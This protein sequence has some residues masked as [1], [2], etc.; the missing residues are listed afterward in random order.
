MG[1]AVPAP[2]PGPCMEPFED[3]VQH[4][5]FVVQD[6]AVGEGGQ[7]VDEF[8]KPGGGVRAVAGLQPRR[9]TGGGQ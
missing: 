6:V 9:V 3:V 4:A 2:S 1:A 5:Y 8:G 7:R